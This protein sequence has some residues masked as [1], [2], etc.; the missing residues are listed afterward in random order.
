MKIGDRL[1]SLRKKHKL[2]RVEL[3]TMLG[4]HEKSI[5]SIE[6][7]RYGLKASKLDALAKLYNMTP[8]EILDGVENRAA[9]R[10]DTTNKWV[11]APTKTLSVTKKRVQVKPSGKANL[12]NVKIPKLEVAPAPEPITQLDTVLRED[13]RRA[14]MLL[15]QA[16]GGTTSLSA[17]RAH[18]RVT[19]EWGDA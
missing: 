17:I 14:N 4:W 11:C 8:T 7:N 19:Q 10:D 5:A 18:L 2:S 1:L 3:G 12:S 13:L 16:L 15:E 9:I 6:N